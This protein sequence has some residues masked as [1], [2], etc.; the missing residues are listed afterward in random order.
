MTIHPPLRRNFLFSPPTPL[1]FV[2]EYGTIIKPLLRH[3][4]Q[5]STRSGRLAQLVEHLLDVQE[6]TGSSPVPSTKTKPRGQQASGFCF[7]RASQRRPRFESCTAAQPSRVLR[8]KQARQSRGRGLNFQA[9]CMRAGNSG[10]RNPTHQTVRIRTRSCIRTGSDT[11]F[12]YQKFFAGRIE[13]TEGSLPPEPANPRPGEWMRHSSERGFFAWISV[14]DGRA[15]LSRATGS[16]R[17][18]EGGRALPGPGGPPECR[19]PPRGPAR[20]AG[21]GPPGGWNSRERCGARSW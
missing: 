18:P 2:S 5:N 17:A 6:V 21:P 16:Q 7:A 10:H 9:H 3:P 14:R 8:T 1:H 13:E 19:P 20:P 4:T 11:F 15:F 12:L